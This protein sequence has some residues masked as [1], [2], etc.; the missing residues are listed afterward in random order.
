MDTKKF[1]QFAQ[2]LNVLL[3]AF[4]FFIFLM[5]IGLMYMI[6]FQRNGL[7]LTVHTPDFAFTSSHDVPSKSAVFWGSAIAGGFISILYMY[8]V[9]RGSVFFSRLSK[10]QTPFSLSN[11]QL[12]KEIGLLTIVLSLV[13]PIL[14]SAVVTFLSPSGYTLIIGIDSTTII[15]FV[16]YFAA[17]IIRYGV[18]L[19]RLSD[20]TV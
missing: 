1:Q 16:I 12:L 9:F 4:C 11:Y 17:E 15:G 13:S 5:M 20:E 10:G 18:T 6:V 3:K 19:Q 8:I 14:Y 7:T 2:I